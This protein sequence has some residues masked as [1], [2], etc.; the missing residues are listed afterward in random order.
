MGESI[1]A[2]EESA[3]LDELSAWAAAQLFGSILPYWA[4]NARDA[5][6]EGFLGEIA[7]DGT[8]VP[9]AERTVVGVARHLWTFSAAADAAERG[10]YGADP[11]LI[12][13]SPSSAELRTLADAAYGY[14]SS[15]FLDERHG[16]FFWAVESSG[17][18]TVEKKQIYGQA[19]ALYAL[20]EYARVG[21]ADSARR[22]EARTLA[23]ET[24]ALLDD[25]AR[26]DRWGGYLEALARDWSPTAD[27]V[28][29]PVDLDCDKSMNTNLHV[30]EA[31]SAL[32]R[33]DPSPVHREALVSELAVMARSVF[34][35]DGHLGLFF[36]SDWTRLDRKLSY[37]HDIEASWLMEEARELADRARELADRGG[38]EPAPEDRAVFDDAR[39]AIAALARTALEEGVDPRS[40]G[41]EDEAVPAVAEP[42]VAE[43]AIEGGLHRHGKRIWWCQAEALVGFLGA[44]ERTREKRYLEAA[45]ATR[46]FIDAHIVD[47]ELGDWRW[48]TDASGTPLP[49]C[50]KGGNWKTGYHNGRACIEVLR[51]C[52]EARSST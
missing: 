40:G 47:R 36:R 39:R 8:P 23:G 38:A 26:E 14:L 45:R 48:G 11:E 25:W 37:G 4:A 41:I 22:K 15:R 16:G 18:P 21:A 9:E 51:R 6:G 17:R 44:W 30:L 35:A 27:R 12:A 2:G 3:V 33:L 20:S 50:P 1:L 46:G 43:S 34:Q 42:A 7:A 5:A 31:L 24:F 32:Y 19:F 49:G 13:K 10:A 29:S 28:L 52:A